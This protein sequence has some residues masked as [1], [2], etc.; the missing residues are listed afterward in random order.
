MWKRGLMIGLWFP[1]PYKEKEIANEPYYSV[2][3]IVYFMRNSN[4]D[5]FVYRRREV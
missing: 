2:T 5:Y 1:I 4:Y 3:V